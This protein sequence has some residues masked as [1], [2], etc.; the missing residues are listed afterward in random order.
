MKAGSILG[1]RHR[2]GGVVPR[3]V[4]LMRPIPNVDQYRQAGDGEPIVI[5]GIVSVTGPGQFQ[6]VRVGRGRLLPVP[7]RQ[8][9][10]QRAPH[11]YSL[12]R[13][14]LESRA[15]VAS[16]GQLIRDHK[17]VVLVGNMSFVD[18]GANQGLYEKEDIMVIAGVGVPRD[19]F[20]QK[21]YAPTNAGPR[22]SNT[23][24]VMD[25]AQ[26][27]SRQD[28]APGLHR[29]KY[30]KRRRMVLHRSGGVDQ[31]AGWRRQDHRLRPGF[32]RC[33]HP[34]SSRRWRSSPT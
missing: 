18:C 14:C 32:A 6:F 3:P 30:S 1:H 17:A 15:V 21:N 25:V 13:R 24:A 11:Q 29:A 28:Q 2:N 34:S 10:H 19:C 16:R 12:E 20:F 31:E 5:G 22:V 7:R 4:Q 33:S 23:K 9:R 26:S 27:L 8:W